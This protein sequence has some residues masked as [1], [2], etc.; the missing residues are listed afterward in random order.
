VEVRVKD[1]AVI[2]EFNGGAGAFGIAF[3]GANIWVADTTG[4]SV[5]KL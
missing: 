2:G 4:K 3:D 5:S 1:G